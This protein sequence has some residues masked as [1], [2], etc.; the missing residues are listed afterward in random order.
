MFQLGDELEAASVFPAAGFPNNSITDGWVLATVSTAFP[1]ANGFFRPTTGP[2]SFSCSR[3]RAMGSMSV[4]SSQRGEQ[5]QR[6]ELDR[7]QHPA[8]IHYR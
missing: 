4:R 8:F 2:T 3:T 7:S 6:P 5:P 1:N